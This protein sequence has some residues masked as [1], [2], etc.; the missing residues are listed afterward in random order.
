MDTELNNLLKSL[1]FKY[2]NKEFLDGDPSWFM[3]QVAGDTNKELLAFVA[4]CL[5]Y[6]SRK[7][8]MPKIQ[9]LLDY[10][11]GDMAGW[12]ANGRFEND[13][14]D[15][16]RRCYYRLYNYSTM[17]RMLGALQEMINTYGSIRGYLTHHKR[18]LT[19]LEA[20]EL[21]VHF[22]SERDITGIIPK[23]TKSSCKRLCM[24]LRWM[25][26]SDSPV[27]IGIW[28]DIIDRRSLIIPMDT[29]VIQ[30]ACRLGLLKSKTASMSTAIKLTEELKTCFP[31][32]PAK[33]DFALFGYGV[34][35]V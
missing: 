11:Q 18:Q 7:Q 21:L 1:A 22:F 13:I 10:A 29:H 30:Q 35:N 23:D 19:C 32:D 3:H 26:R 34:N 24:F 5:S 20:V 4:S 31:N 14:P 25:V 33:G 27:D 2:E 28:S 17:H 16:E 12:I 9:L 8:F 6:G 15:D